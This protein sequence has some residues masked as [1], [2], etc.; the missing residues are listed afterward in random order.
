MSVTVCSVWVCDQFA[1]WQ[2]ATVLE[3]VSASL[4]TPTRHLRR[5]GLGASAGIHPAIVPPLLLFTKACWDGCQSPQDRRLRHL[6]LDPIQPFGDVFQFDG[7]TAELQ[8]R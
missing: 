7:I 8:D 6:A 3:E 1:T 2:P 4:S 5:P